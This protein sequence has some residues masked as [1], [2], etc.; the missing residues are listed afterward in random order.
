MTV[1]ILA[2]SLSIFL[3]S[4]IYGIRGTFR[5][6]SLAPIPNI[7]IPAL[8]HSEVLDSV[9]NNYSFLEIFAIIL[10]FALRFY[11]NKTAGGLRLKSVGLGENAAETAGVNINRTKFLALVFSGII[12][13][14]AGAHLSLGYT[15]FFV[16]SIVSGRGF[17]GIA[18]MFFSGGNPLISW[19][20]CLLFGFIDSVGLRLQSYGAPAEFVL[21][22]P[23]VTT[24]AVLA[25][26]M[27][28]K[29]RKA[30]RET[31][32]V[33]TLKGTEK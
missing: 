24:I 23:Y 28:V 26:S 9:F 16:P 11:L 21:I 4:Q 31:S 32:S 13:G 27:W 2:V 33:R 5:P 12:G 30:L 15:N 10:V 25:C 19:L 1:N 18:A 7:T 22:L 17:M 29:K 8:E 3:I 6:E 14:I 20:A